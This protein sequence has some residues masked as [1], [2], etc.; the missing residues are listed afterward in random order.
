MDPITDE[1]LANF[2]VGSHIRSHP[3]HDPN[4]VVEQQQQLNDENSST[5]ANGGR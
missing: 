3:D 4:S 2:V 5:N 1:R